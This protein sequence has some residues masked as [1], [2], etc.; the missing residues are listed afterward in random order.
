MATLLCSKAV[1]HTDLNVIEHVWE[2]L[3]RRIRK[4]Q[5]SSAAMLKERIIEAWNSITSGELTNLVESMPRRLQAVI[6]ANGGPTK[7]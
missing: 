3:E 4:K 1:K 7:Y 5:I 2:I 6:D